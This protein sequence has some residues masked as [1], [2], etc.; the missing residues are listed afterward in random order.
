VQTKLDFQEVMEKGK[1][2]LILNQLLDMASIASVPNEV[3]K[4]SLLSAFEAMRKRQI[5]R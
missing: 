1:L 3:V 5:L 4:S 2:H